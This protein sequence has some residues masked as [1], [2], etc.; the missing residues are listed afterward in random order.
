VLIDEEQRP[1][2][3]GRQSI[4]LNIRF[5]TVAIH[6]SKCF[7]FS[8]Q[9]QEDIM[10]VRWQRRNAI[11]FASDGA[12]LDPG[13]SVEFKFVLRGNSPRTNYAVAHGGDQTDQACPV[14]APGVKDIPR[15]QAPQRGLP[16][17]HDI[18]SLLLPNEVSF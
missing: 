13:L 5:H 17:G 9:F 10:N 2:L 8:V 12:Q 18:C 16:I 3:S 6:L 14:R 15:D 1:L 11:D 7:V 4:L